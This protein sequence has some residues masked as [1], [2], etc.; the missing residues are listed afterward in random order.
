MKLVGATA[1]YVTAELD[2]GPIIALDVIG[3]SFR[4]SRPKGSNLQKMVLARAVGL[5]LENRVHPYGRKTAVFR[6]A[7]SEE[8]V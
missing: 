7:S 6:P 3:T 8:S 4:R 5:H 2:G 1:H